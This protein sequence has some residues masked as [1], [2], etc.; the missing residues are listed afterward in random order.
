MRVASGSFS[1]PPPVVVLL[2]GF[3][4]G[5]CTFDEGHSVHGHLAKLVGWFINSSPHNST[6]QVSHFVECR[7]TP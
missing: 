7:H 2:L 3:G 6:A 5:S 1:P 4:F